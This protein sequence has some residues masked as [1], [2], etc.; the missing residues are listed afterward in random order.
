MKYNPYNWKISPA[1]ENKC[2]EFYKPEELSMDTD[3]ILTELGSV[4]A[5][6]E[7]KRMK[8][9]ELEREMSVLNQELI[10][11][12]QKKLAIIQMLSEG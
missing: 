7:L 4:C 5:K 11:L 2:D 12:E 6:I 3:C 9:I 1:K 10:D 8:Y